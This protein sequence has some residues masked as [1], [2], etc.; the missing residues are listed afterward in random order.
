MNEQLGARLGERDRQLLRDL[1]E[2]RLATGGQ[3]QRLAF[4]G[5]DATSHNA[6]VARRCL[7]RLTSQNYLQRLD[8]RVGG[9]RAGSSSYIYA[10]APRGAALL[11]RPGGRRFARDPSL[12]FVDHQLA[13]AEVFV[14][15]SEARDHGQL[16]AL[17]VQTEPVCWRPL[18]DGSGSVLKPDLFVLAADDDC[19][20][21]AFIEVDNGTE[22]A[23]ALARKL[24]LYAAHYASGRE[25]A[26]EGVFPEVLWLSED[27]R[28][29]AQ[30]E[31][32]FRR[33]HAPEGLHGALSLNSA[34]DH[35][36]KGGT[37]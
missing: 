14:R 22:H 8:R 32:A 33:A 25:Q 29:R 9:V 11:G 15:L 36:M 20:L 35:L 17:E 24:A 27:Q 28:R 3:L 26:A 34:I 16:T 21:L 4:A 2:L 30:L 13:V 10:L 19:E 37:T 18:D 5:P 23:A 31:L 12:T 6:R 1:A 7:Q